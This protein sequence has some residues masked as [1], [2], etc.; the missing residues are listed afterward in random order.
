MNDG[1]IGVSFVVPVH[2]GAP[3]IRDTIEAIWAQA[4]GRPLEVIVVDDRSDDASPTILRELAIAW[5]LQL[6]QG[7]G[8]GAAAAINLGV[9]AARFPLIGQVDQDVVLQHGW[10]RLL[11]AE[12]ADP[13]VAAAQGYYTIDPNATWCARVMGLDLEQ[14]YTAIRGRDTDHVCTGNAMYRADALHRVGPFDER[15]GYGYDNDMSYRLQNAGCRLTFCRSAQ[16]VHRW[17]EGFAAYCAQQYG[18]GYG[19]LELVA[20]HPGRLS[21]DLVSPAPMMLHPVVMSL[22][23]AGLAGAALMDATAGPWRTAT[24]GATALISCLCVERLVAGI[25]AARRFRDLAPLLFP[26]AH[27][28]RDLAWVAA[29]VMWS[30]RRLGR[31]PTCPSN[32]MRPRASRAAAH[33]SASPAALAPQTRAR[34]LIPARSE[35]ATL[36]TVIAEGRSCCSDLDLLVRDDGA[37]DATSSL[38]ERLTS[39]VRTFPKRLGRLSRS[40]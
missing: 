18:F 12:F 31:C 21:G 4:D 14:R 17:R 22:G 19:R 16:S 27:L 8:L 23:I 32:S 9:R 10:M 2:N 1:R 15:F 13:A 28:A 26:I 35:A 39:R 20:K 34:V 24:V 40:S 29:I 3:W 5:P 11:T 33:T 38:V 25:R 30:I 7:E 36:A 6:L 37:T